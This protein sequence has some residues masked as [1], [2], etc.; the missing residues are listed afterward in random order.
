VQHINGFGSVPSY[1]L[2]GTTSPTSVGFVASGGLQFS[3][4][5]LHVT[6][7]IRYT[8]WSGNS[9]TDSLLRPLLGSRD[10]AQFL[11]GFTF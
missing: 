3:V 5:A 10:Q 1:L 2:S 8:R 6:P 9:W 7:E 4:G 11:V